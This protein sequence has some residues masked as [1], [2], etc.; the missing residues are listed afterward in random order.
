MTD[1]QESNRFRQVF[2]VYCPEGHLCTMG[3]KHLK[4]SNTLSGA[5][6][7]LAQHRHSGHGHSTQNHN[8]EFCLTAA[9]RETYMQ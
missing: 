5:R 8:W 1:A 9:A 2:T 7:K 4:Y 3:G 6:R